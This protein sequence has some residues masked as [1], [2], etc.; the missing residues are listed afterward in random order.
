MDL[1]Q[2]PTTDRATIGR[3]A[4]RVPTLGGALHE[5]RRVGLLTFDVFAVC[6]CGPGGR[7]DQPEQC[8]Q[9]ST[10]AS[11]TTSDQRSQRTEGARRSSDKIEEAT[12]NIHDGFLA[13]ELAGVA[14]DL[15]I[16]W[17]PVDGT[18]ECLS[19]PGLRGPIA[20]APVPIDRH[21]VAQ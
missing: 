1:A 19:R 10:V 7:T 17:L 4:G 18:R 8:N 15:Q 12:I 21:D 3:R 13:G 11:P 16:E 9:R 5:L 20:S 6:R 2:K 14:H